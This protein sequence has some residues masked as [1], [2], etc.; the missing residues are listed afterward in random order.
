MEPE[1]NN[2]TSAN[3]PKR[4]SSNRKRDR[5]RKKRGSKAKGG[6]EGNKKPKNTLLPSQTKVPY[7]SSLPPLPVKR[8]EEPLLECPLCGKVIETIASA[9]THPSG[10]FC[11]FDCVLEKITKDE[12]LSEQQKVSY[13][14]R[15]TFAVVEPNQETGFSFVKKIVWETPETFD[16][17]KKYVEA[18][19]K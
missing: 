3:Q 14:G 2:K 13:V 15:G 10:G 4:D 6:A 5:K 9:L 1:S 17:M 8:V 12:H 16:T 11:H 18:N 7:H 19:K